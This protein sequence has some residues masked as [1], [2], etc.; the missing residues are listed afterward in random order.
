MQDAGQRNSEQRKADS[1]GIQ[2]RRRGSTAPLGNGREFSYIL[3][4]GRACSIF[5]LPSSIFRNRHLHPHIGSPHVVHP[6][7]ARAGSDTEALPSCPRHGDFR[8][9]VPSL[10]IVLWIHMEER[11]TSISYACAG[12]DGVIAFIDGRR[13]KNDDHDNLGKVLDFSFLSSCSY[14]L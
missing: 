10:L 7:L 9:P 11:Q 14:S 2:Q 1:S 6:R 13:A 5:H 4:S 3:L 8:R 12:P